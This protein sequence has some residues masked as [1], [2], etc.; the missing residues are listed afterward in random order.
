M[1]SRE[2]TMPSFESQT[3]N[4]SM[5]RSCLPSVTE[6]TRTTSSIAAVR[7]KALRGPGLEASPIRRER[8]LAHRCTLCA[9]RLQAGPLALS[10]T[11]VQPP[12]GNPH[13]VQ[14]LAFAVGGEQPI[15]ADVVR[16]TRSFTGGR[17]LTRMLLRLRARS[18]PTD[19]LALSSA[20]RLPP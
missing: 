19:G 3:R 2:E 4:S 10:S 5:K 13:T 11:C 1:S 20:G 6:S 7:A 18:R 15:T 9:S 8:H 12:S 16:A 14:F 17:K